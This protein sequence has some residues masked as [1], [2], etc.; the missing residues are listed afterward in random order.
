MSISVGR[1]SP[2]RMLLPRVVRIRGAVLA[3]IVRPLYLCSLDSPLAPRDLDGRTRHDPLFHASRH[4][5]PHLL[6]LHLGRLPLCSEAVRPRT[7]GGAGGSRSGG[8]ERSSS[9]AAAAP[10]RPG[11]QER[12][13]SATT[14]DYHRRP[15]R[16]CESDSHFMELDDAADVSPSQR[17]GVG[18]RLLRIEVDQL[19]ASCRRTAREGDRQCEKEEESQPRPS[20]GV[21]ESLWFH[22][23][24]HA[25]ISIGRSILLYLHVTV[26]ATTEPWVGLREMR[27]PHRILLRIGVSD[28]APGLLRF[29]M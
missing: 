24:H 3:D 6:R 27:A 15:F 8:R 20:G 5:A 14:I 4:P 12:P 29:P 17:P 16:I 23:F 13:C 19:P 22:E 11:H 2:R 9:R 1:Y 25:S 18:V 10:W 26:N 21:S 28:K 7:T